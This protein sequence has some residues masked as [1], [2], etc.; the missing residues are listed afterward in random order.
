M[1]EEK[2]TYK[3]FIYIDLLCINIFLLFSLLKRAIKLDENYST[4]FFNAAALYL[5]DRRFQDALAYLDKCL[6]LNQEDA[7]ALLNRGISRILLNDTKVIYCF[8]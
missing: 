3:N 7:S 5:R 4:A 6:Q 1:R 8:V 2:L